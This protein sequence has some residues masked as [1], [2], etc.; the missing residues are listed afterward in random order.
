MVGL[1]RT[2]DGF[3]LFPWAVRMVASATPMGRRA[4]DFCA[5]LGPVASLAAVLTLGPSRQWLTMQLWAVTTLAAASC[6]GRSRPGCRP[7]PGPLRPWLYVSSSGRNA[8]GSRNAV[9]LLG[10][11]S[12]ASVLALG[13]DQCGFRRGFGPF[14]PWLA[15][16][17]WAVPYLAPVRALGRACHGFRGRDGPPAQWLYVHALGRKSSSSRVHPGP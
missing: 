12:M 14:S 11:S 7:H 13:R 2:A 1:G 3:T 6:L 8:S 9:G 4:F 16:S 5:C 10:R 15:P 17:S